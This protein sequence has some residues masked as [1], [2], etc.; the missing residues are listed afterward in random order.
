MEGTFSIHA[1]TDGERT[2]LWS[3]ALTLKRYPGQNE[4]GL[5]TWDMLGLPDGPHHDDYVIVFQGQL[6]A[7]ENAVAGRVFQ[8]VL[9]VNVIDAI[10]EPIQDARVGASVSAL[11]DV[12]LSPRI[13]VLPPAF[14]NEQGMARFYSW[15]VPEGATEF[16]VQPKKGSLRVYHEGLSANPEGLTTIALQLKGHLR[17]EMYY[18]TWLGAASVRAEDGRVLVRAISCGY[19]TDNFPTGT[20]SVRRWG[21]RVDATGMLSEEEKVVV[22][23]GHQYVVYRVKDRE[24]RGFP[25]V[26]RPVWFW[27]QDQDAWP[28]SP[29]VGW[30]D[31]DKPCVCRYPDGDSRVVDWFVQGDPHVHG[32]DYR[33]SGRLRATLNYR[34]LCDN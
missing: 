32:V 21:I 28:G 10:D 26:F 1:T 16:L 22:R 31:T 6:G 18:E 27:A 34:G 24:V 13:I 29:F 23:F 25:N 11:D 30:P 3:D 9:E 20:M 17:V 7:E 14:T 2:E 12:P 33:P 8:A 19:T 15:E 5:I 4:S